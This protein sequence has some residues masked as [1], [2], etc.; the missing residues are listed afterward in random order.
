MLKGYTRSM[1]VL[2]GF[3]SGIIL[4]SFIFLTLQFVTDWLPDL[5]YL[6]I[7]VICTAV[8]TGILLYTNEKANQN[9][10][11]SPENREPKRKE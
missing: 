11:N 7:S 4:C 10:Q 9:R 6:L 5:T 3:A 8:G 1:K 2:F